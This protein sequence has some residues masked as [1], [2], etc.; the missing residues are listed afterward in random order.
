M[1]RSGYRHFSRITLLIIILIAR[2][3]FTWFG[4]DLMI[5]ECRMESPP[6]KAFC[7]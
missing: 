3:M 1:E 4:L 2:Q 5:E 6:G 7:L